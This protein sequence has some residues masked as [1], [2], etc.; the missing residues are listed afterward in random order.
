[1]AKIN[2]IIGMRSI[3]KKTLSYLKNKKSI[4]K[5][6]PVCPLGKASLLIP[7]SEFNILCI[8]SEKINP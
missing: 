1:V 3:Q 5:A 2:K 6:I 4:S 7:S 8:L